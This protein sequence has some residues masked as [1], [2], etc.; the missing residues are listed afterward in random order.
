MAEQGFPNFRVKGFF[1]LVAPAGTP[2]AILER[3]NAIMVEYARRPDVQAKMTGMQV[4]A[5]PLSRQQTDAY[6]L[7]ESTRWEQV[8][9]TSGAKAE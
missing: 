8:V 6:L 4:S 5:L 9:K 3:L 1:T 2:E 7:K